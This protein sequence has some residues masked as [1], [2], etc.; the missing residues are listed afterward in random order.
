MGDVINKGGIIY[1]FNE[2]IARDPKRNITFH[3]VDEFD[4]DSTYGEMIVHRCIG[5]NDNTGDWE[6]VS[7]IG[8]MFQSLRE[9][10]EEGGTMYP[11]MEELLKWE[12]SDSPRDYQERALPNYTIK[13]GKVITVDS[14]KD[15]TFIAAD[16]TYLDTSTHGDIT[17]KLAVG[18]NS[19]GK[20][21]MRL[22]PDEICN[23]KFSWQIFGR[24]CP[25]VHIQWWGMELQHWAREFTE[26]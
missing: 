26:Y 14:V 22:S 8:E 23:G 10:R 6:I 21:V 3:A 2:V 7:T 4:L 19:D 12:Q 5:V 11:W 13:F 20:E 15:I 18:M 1:K 9:R 25:D 16:I 17:D 24:W